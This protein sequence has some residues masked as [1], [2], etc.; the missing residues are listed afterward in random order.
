[1]IVPD[2]ATV[3]THL[4]RLHIVLDLWLQLLDAI[5]LVCHII[6]PLVQLCDRHLVC[7]QHSEHFT[8]LLNQQVI[9]SLLHLDLYAIQTGAGVFP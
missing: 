9:V 1:M 2:W 8:Q 3:T 6:K 7:C 4:D 5:P